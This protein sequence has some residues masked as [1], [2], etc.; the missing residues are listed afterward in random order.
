MEDYADFIDIETYLNNI[1]EKEFIS[2]F[3]DFEGDFK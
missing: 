2:E 1:D 3:A